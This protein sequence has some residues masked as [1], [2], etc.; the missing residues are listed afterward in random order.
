LNK[1]KIVDLPYSTGDNGKFKGNYVEDK[2][3]VYVGLFPTKERAFTATVEHM[4]EHGADVPAL[5]MDKYLKVKK[6][7]T[8][9]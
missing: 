3:C 5:L 8:A 7:P 6:N 9:F 1:R 2:R 4:L